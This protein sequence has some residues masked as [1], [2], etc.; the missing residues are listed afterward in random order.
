[1]NLSHSQ[2]DMAHKEQEKKR[3]SE[4]SRVCIHK[5]YN[6]FSAGYIPRALLSTS[7]CVVPARRWPAR[8]MSRAAACLHYAMSSRR[9]FY[10]NAHENFPFLLWAHVEFP[11]F[12]IIILLYSR[13]MASL[14]K[15]CSFLLLSPCSLPLIFVCMCL[16]EWSGALSLSS[17]LSYIHTNKLGLL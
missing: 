14:N 3:S 7:F 5:V 1:M 17:S 2:S 12:V 4:M 16:S 11:T 10:Y 9:L 8:K 13:R 15:S 6:V